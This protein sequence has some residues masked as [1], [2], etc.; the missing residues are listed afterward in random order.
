VFQVMYFRL[1]YTE[2]GHDDLPIRSDLCVEARG[3]K[4]A[5]IRGMERIGPDFILLDCVEESHPTNVTVLP[6]TYTKQRTVRGV[7][8]SKLLT[9]LQ[10]GRS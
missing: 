8:V 5:I 9:V 3:Y 7:K 4:D 6:I 1:H 10:G 2:A